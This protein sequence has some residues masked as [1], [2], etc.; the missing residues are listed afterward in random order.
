VIYCEDM[1][2]ETAYVKLMWV[3][4]HTSDKEK[5]RE[6]MLTDYAGEIS[7]KSGIKSEKKDFND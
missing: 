7:T 5:A 2:A 4:G 1:L 3:L 6:M